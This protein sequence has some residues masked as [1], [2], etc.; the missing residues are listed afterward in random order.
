[1][2]KAA[3]FFSYKIKKNVTKEEFIEI[4]KKL[5]DNV[6]SKVK[7]FIS[8]EHFQHDNLWTDYVLWETYDDAINAMKA[9]QGK[10]E[11]KYFYNCIQLY[12][13]RTI[14]SEFVIKY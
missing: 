7:G 12:T 8:W 1:M 11:A 13:C 5:H 6:I 14:V 2:S 9:G 4:T 10:D 3:W